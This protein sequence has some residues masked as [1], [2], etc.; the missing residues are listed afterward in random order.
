MLLQGEVQAIFYRK[1]RFDLIDKK[2]YFLHKEPSSKNEK[3]TLVYAK[4][5][6]K[7]T[8]KE[9]QV[10]NTHLSFHEPN[11]RLNEV[12]AVRKAVQ[13]LPKNMPIILTGDF[14]TFPNRTDID[15]PFYDGDCLIKAL[16]TPRIYDSKD[17]AIFGHI[18]PIATTNFNQKTK[19]SFVG[20][21]IPGVF[22]DRIIIRF[23][24][25]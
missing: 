17:R 11:K 1:D 8:N 21:G 24:L 4:F 2:T 10:L 12:Y 9:L 6:D 3:N 16:T 14:N 7:K 15:L 25:S 5:K 20:E 23:Y 18:G 19:E 22:L 13:S